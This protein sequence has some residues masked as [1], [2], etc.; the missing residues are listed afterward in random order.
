MYRYPRSR[1]QSNRRPPGLRHEALTSLRVETDERC[2]EY[3]IPIATRRQQVR[4]S[5]VRLPYLASRKL[6]QDPC[7]E[8]FSHD[9]D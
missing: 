8:S 2:N 6:Q 4:S 9:G 1:R 3:G 5:G 7:S